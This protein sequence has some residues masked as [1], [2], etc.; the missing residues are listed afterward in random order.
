M[1]QHIFEKRVLKELAAVM[2]LLNS[3]VLVLTF[4]L[5][6]DNSLVIKEV[7]QDIVE[8]CIL[9][10]FLNLLKIFLRQH[11]ENFICCSTSSRP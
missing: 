8:L 4:S 6:R 1:F 10:T 3:V 9:F 2:L 7:H 11:R 5:I